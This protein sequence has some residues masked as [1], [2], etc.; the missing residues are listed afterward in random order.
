MAEKSSSATCLESPHWRLE[1][2]P[3]FVDLE[4]DV[5]GLPALGLPFTPGDE[6]TPPHGHIELHRGE[7]GAD[8][9]PRGA[10]DRKPGEARQLDDAGETGFVIEK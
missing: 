3:A 1:H 8:R 7:D 10:L 4:E 2:E 9:R 5:G 6:E